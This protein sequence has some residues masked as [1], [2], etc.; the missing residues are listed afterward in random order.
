MEAT[1][2]KIQDTTRW[3]VLVYKEVIMN[4]IITEA[5]YFIR[6]NNSEK[7][8]LKEITDEDKPIIV[9]YIEESLADL[10]LI[11]ANYLTR[12]YK[13]YDIDERFLCFDIMVID[14]MNESLII[15]LGVN[16]ENFIVHSVLDRWFDPP[17]VKKEYYAK[18][19]RETLN[20]RKY[21]KTKI[22][23]LL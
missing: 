12:P 1:V 3:E 22:R 18:K 17:I 2:I 4:K 6:K 11:I 8:P 9:S 14:G 15:P 7:N 19:I 10:L 23:P 13:D 20:Y 21:I 16:I 5:L